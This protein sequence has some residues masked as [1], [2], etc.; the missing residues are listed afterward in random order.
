MLISIK[1]V[2]SP[3]FAPKTKVMEQSYRF[4]LSQVCILRAFY[5]FPLQVGGK[6]HPCDVLGGGDTDDDPKREREKQVVFQ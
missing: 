1:G 6:L 3:F 5:S 2:R 4:F